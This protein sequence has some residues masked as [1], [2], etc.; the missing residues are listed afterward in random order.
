MEQMLNAF[1]YG[2]IVTVIGMLVVFFGLALLIVCISIMSGIF[3]A[4]AKK[5]IDAAPIPAQTTEIAPA[6][7][8]AEPENDVVDDA[9]LIAVIA[10]AIVAF[11]DSGKRLVVRRVRRVPG[12][13]RAAREEQ[14]ARF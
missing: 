6:A 3:K 13:N 7:P 10:A 1:S 8:A 14:V 4:I 5:K 2:G 11:D 12:W 9:E